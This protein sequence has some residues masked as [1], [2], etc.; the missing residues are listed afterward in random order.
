[1]YLSSLASVDAQTDDHPEPDP[2]LREEMEHFQNQIREY[3]I[4][5]IVFIVLYLGSAALIDFYRRKND[6][7]D[8]DDDNNNNDD[9][10]VVFSYLSSKGRMVV[11]EVGNLLLSKRGSVGPSV[12]GF[13]VG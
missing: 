10:D 2:L 8:D 3:V 12:G 4:S 9:D 1:M 6:D 5:L 7:G 13:L 11:G